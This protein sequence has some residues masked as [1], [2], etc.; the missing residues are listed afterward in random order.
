MSI[1]IEPYG[2]ADAQWV[3]AQ[4]EAELLVRYGFVGD[5]E[6]SGALAEFEGPAGAFLVA[7][8]SGQAQPAGGVGLRR[9]DGPDGDGGPIGEVKRLW[10]DPTCRGLGIG[11]S[12]MAAL[13]AAAVD[14]GYRSLRLGTGFR[15][16]E[17]Q[18]L[19]TR[20]GWLRQLLTWDGEPIPPGWVLF[21]KGLD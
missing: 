10:V 4:A 14:L 1:G 8:R 9:H 15:Q 6:I 5:P 7:R 3:V 16:P 2:D 18:A 21:A 12:L 17:A 19:Y 20:T 11:R 13:E